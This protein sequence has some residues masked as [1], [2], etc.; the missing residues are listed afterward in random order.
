VNA[1]PFLTVFRPEV[2]SGNF[3]GD[4]QCPVCN[5]SVAVFKLGLDL[6]PLRPGQ[7]R[8]ARV[9]IQRMTSGQSRS[10]ALGH[11]A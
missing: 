7:R 9:L 8:F 10:A 3:R 2:D 4:S 11:Q 6:K 1:T 5:H